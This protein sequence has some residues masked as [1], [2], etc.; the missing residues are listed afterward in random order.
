M[1]KEEHP[2]SFLRRPVIPG[3]VFFVLDPV[4]C[5]S[6]YS[7]YTKPSFLQ[8]A[9][10]ATTDMDPYWRPLFLRSW[11]GLRTDIPRFHLAPPAVFPSSTAVP[12]H[13]CGDAGKADC[14]VSHLIFLCA[15]WT[16][17]CSLGSMVEW[18]DAAF[19]FL[20]G[21]KWSTALSHG[22]KYQA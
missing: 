15:G 9:T 13:A 12:S 2:C 16:P 3:A 7:D 6:C 11:T 4:P 19:G 21:K 17:H 10:S 22:Q 8:R 5:A 20:R 18:C 14:A 1:L